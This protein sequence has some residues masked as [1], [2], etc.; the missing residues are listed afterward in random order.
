MTFPALP[1]MSKAH[2]SSKPNVFYTMY[3]S[4]KDDRRLRLDAFFQ[5]GHNPVNKSLQMLSVK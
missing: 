2:I 1:K 3:L 4:T 5:K